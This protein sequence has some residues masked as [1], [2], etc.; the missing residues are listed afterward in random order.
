MSHNLEIYTFNCTVNGTNTRNKLHLHKLTANLTLFWKGVY[1][2]STKIFNELPEYIAQLIVDKK[3]FISILKKYL[4]DK[5][6]YS[7]EE[8]IN[9]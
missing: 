4:A 2:I 5:S 1:Y 6:F 7:H 3:N 8:F 9:D